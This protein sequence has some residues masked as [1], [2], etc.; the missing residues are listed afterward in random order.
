ML[1][2]NSLRELNAQLAR[3][4]RDFAISLGGGLISRKH[5]TPLGTC[6]YELFNGIDGSLVRARTGRELLRATNIGLAIERGAFFCE[7][8][9]LDAGSPREVERAAAPGG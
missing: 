2:V 3:G 5:I 1:R 8:C 4:H 7:E 9:E 6:G